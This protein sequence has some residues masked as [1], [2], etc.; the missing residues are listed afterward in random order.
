[1]T[2]IVLYDFELDENCYKVRL[3]LSTLGLAYRKIAVNMFP[4]REHLQPPLLELNPRGSLPILADGEAVLCEAEAILA[5]LVRA[6]GGGGQWLPEEPRH[7]GLVASWLQFASR[8]LHAAWMLRRHA[9]LDEPAD[10]AALS[11]VVRKAFRTMEDHMTSREFDD[12][13]WFVGKR[14]S[15][16]EIALFPAIALSRDFGIDHEAYPALRRW[17][18]RV[19]SIPGFLT[20]P[21]IPD[22]Y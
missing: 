11:T 15:L 5:Y 22:Y 21:G 9:V 7:F 17:M 3:M 16:A 14:P 19:R 6:Y 18:R 4:G 2:E 1:M 13:E 8:D 12:G 20:M 10:A